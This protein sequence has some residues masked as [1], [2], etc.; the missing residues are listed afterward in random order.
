MVVSLVSNVQQ[1]ELSFL[2]FVGEIP[3]SSPY[4][5][6]VLIPVEGYDPIEFTLTKECGLS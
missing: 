5:V 1:Y 2:H 6:N 3:R 4:E